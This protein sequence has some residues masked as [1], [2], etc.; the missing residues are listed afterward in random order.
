LDGEF[1]ISG[2][3]EGPRKDGKFLVSWEGYASSGNTWEPRSNLPEDI[4]DMWVRSS[5]EESPAK[6]P[7]KSPAMS[8]EALAKFHRVRAVLHGS[9]ASVALAAATNAT[10]VSTGDPPTAAEGDDSSDSSGD[11]VPIA[12]ELSGLSPAQWAAAS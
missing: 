4:E 10:L 5:D 2:V 9:R 3:L 6:S 11:D 7:A 1:R 12:A 8:P